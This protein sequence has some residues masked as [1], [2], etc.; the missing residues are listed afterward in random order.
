MKTDP[1]KMLR[2]PVVTEKSTALK[3]ARNQVIFEVVQ[4]ATKPM[5]KRAVEKAFN[6]KVSAVNTMVVR[7]KVKR[8]GR[9]AGKRANWKKAVVTLAPGQ[10]IQLFEGV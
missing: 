5:I 1:T 7:G 6:V 9:F 2:R 4:E 3:Q 10:D 8:M